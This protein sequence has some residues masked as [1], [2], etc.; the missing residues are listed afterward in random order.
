MS[1]YR[2]AS[3]MFALS[4]V[5]CAAAPTSQPAKSTSTETWQCSGAVY[6]PDGPAPSKIV[7]EVE[8][9]PRLAEAWERTDFAVSSGKYPYRFRA[10]RRFDAASK[11]GSNVIVDSLGG[12]TVTSSVDGE[13]W[14]GESRG[15]M[16]AMKIKDS[17][18]VT[19]PGKMKMVGQ[20]SP[21]GITW[22]LG[23]DLSCAR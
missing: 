4:S 7:L 3:V 5:A 2:F 22:H 14:T 18:T 1:S 13:I 23:Y 15:P 16:G 9:D 17:E 8:R 21:D 19:A 10:Y 12:Y 6:G 20:Y 11:T